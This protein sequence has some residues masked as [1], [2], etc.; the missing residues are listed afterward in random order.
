MISRTLQVAD[1]AERTLY[2]RDAIKDYLDLVTGNK[3][4]QSLSLTLDGTAP[5]EKATLNA[6]IFLTDNL[7]DGAVRTAL[8][9]LTPLAFSAAFKLQDM[10]IEWILR[11]NGVDSWKFSEK[12]ERYRARKNEGGLILPPFFASQPKV[13]SAFFELYCRLTAR[14]NVLTHGS[15]FTV[16]QDGA[17]TIADEA[18]RNMTLSLSDLQ[19]YLFACGEIIDVLLNG[20]DGSGEAEPLDEIEAVLYDLRRLHNVGL[21]KRTIRH[22]NA[23]LE[24]H[25]GALASTSPIQFRIEAKSL[26][27]RLSDPF[28]PPPG[29]PDPWQV[30]VHLEVRLEGEGYWLVWRPPPTALRGGGTLVFDEATTDA[31]RIPSDE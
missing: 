1:L 13:H 27:A 4:S 11:A 2:E 5:I 18:E 25:R 20:G 22:I 21:A 17:I 6:M 15:S 28:M 8:L 7:C 30:R 31:E 14:R 19:A 29:T 23:T 12:C 3:A 24:V 16:A 10:T 26:R 9:R